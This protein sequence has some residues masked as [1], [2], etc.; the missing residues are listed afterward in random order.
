MLF[1][2]MKSSNSAAPSHL[3]QPIL[4]IRNRA[5]NFSELIMFRLAVNVV[6]GGCSIPKG[7][8]PRRTWWR[9]NVKF[10]VALVD[11]S[12]SVTIRLVF[13]WLDP[14]ITSIKRPIAVNFTVLPKMGGSS[15]FQSWILQ[16]RTTNLTFDNFYVNLWAMQTE[17]TLF[18]I[19]LLLFSFWFLLSF[20]V[21]VEIHGFTIIL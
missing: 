19:F 21:Y 4:K 13:I 2:I 6:T 1:N 7:N 17:S 10:W 14:N 11:I 18:S 12:L 8:H 5:P 3:F 15:L 16:L 20:N 9:A